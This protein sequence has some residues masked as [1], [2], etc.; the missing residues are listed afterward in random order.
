MIRLVRGIDS[1]GLRFYLDG[2]PVHAGTGL[3]V[4]LPGDRALAAEL[5]RLAADAVNGHGAGVLRAAARDIGERW[6]RVR[7]EVEG[8][9][10][11]PVLHLATGGPWE[12][13]SPPAGR[14]EGDEIEAPCEDCAGAGCG[15][16]DGT[17][18]RWIEVQ[19]PR[20]PTVILRGDRDDPDLARVDLR[21]PPVLGSAP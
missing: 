12:E 19:R 8:A 1:G 7:F 5:L 14:A 4:R 6:A 10:E 3:E 20:P 16:C 9:D 13:W 21:W 18:R 11:R 17:G 2:R 15:G